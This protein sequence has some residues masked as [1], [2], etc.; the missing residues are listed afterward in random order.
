[1]VLSHSK[2]EFEPFCSYNL[3]ALASQFNLPIASPEWQESSNF[4]NERVKIFS[5]SSF[6]RS[7]DIFDICA[8]LAEF[9][10]QY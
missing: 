2:L 9:E 3:F 8:F 5:N 10:L 4:F 6:S 7:F 1:M